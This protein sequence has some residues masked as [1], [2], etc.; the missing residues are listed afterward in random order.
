M[1][2]SIDF[3]YFS[4]ENSTVKEKLD[5]NQINKLKELRN[6]VSDEFENY[7]KPSDRVLNYIG[8]LFVVNE[9][10]NSFNKRRELSTRL[11]FNIIFLA[12]R[13]FLIDELLM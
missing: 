13:R 12:T 7:E 2:G 6:S 3:L 10:N 4:K 9:R 5:E 1:N 11:K 8:Q